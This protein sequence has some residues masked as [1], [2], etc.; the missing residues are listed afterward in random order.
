MTLDPPQGI[1]GVDVADDDERGVVGD[2]VAA[3]VPVQVVAGHRL[4]IGQ[5]ADGR[6]PVRVRL[7]RGR[8]QLLIEQ[9]IGIV[10]AALQLGDDD[11]AL[12]LA[13][14]RDG[15]GSCAMRSDSMNSM[16]S[17]ASRVAVSR[18]VVWSIQV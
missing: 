9:L 2:V 4:Q 12:R 3:V 10:F 18:Y 13:V 11:R 15:T 1:V 8:G 6:M 16:R 7:E 14:V 5:P 17:S